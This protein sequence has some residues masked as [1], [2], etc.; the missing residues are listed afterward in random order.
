[1]EEVPV[2]RDLVEV[3]VV[4]FLISG[5]MNTLPEAAEAAEV[6]EEP[7]MLPESVPVEPV[8]EA[9]EAAAPV[10]RTIVRTVI[11]PILFRERAAPVAHQVA[12]PVQQV[13][14]Q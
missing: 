8:A 1:M 14:E 9:A 2:R 10:Q 13:R 12:R 7:M 3:P 4:M 6:A 5:L 11:I